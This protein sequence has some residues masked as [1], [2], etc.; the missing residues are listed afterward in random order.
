MI[1]QP[2]IDRDAITKRFSQMQNMQ[3]LL[4]LLNYIKP[5]LY[6]EKSIAFTERQLNYFSLS[7]HKKKQYRQFFIPKKN[8]TLRT[9]DAPVAT[10]KHIQACLNVALQLLHTP[11]YACNGFITGKSIVDNARL[12]VAKKFVYNLDLKDFFPSIDQKRVWACLLLPPFNLGNS[13]ERKQIANRI[14]ILCCAPLK[15]TASEQVQIKSVLPQGAPTSPFLTNVV[16]QKLDRRLQGVANRFQLSYSR[17]A[18]DITFSS[19]K[20]FFSEDSEVVAEI[21]RIIKDQNFAVNGEKVRLQSSD[22]RQEVTGLIVNE[23]VNV[24]K[25]YIRQLR[26]WIYL[27]ETYGHNKAYRFFL[28]DYIADRGNVKSNMP[29]M[30]CVL[31]G[32]LDYLKMVKGENDSVYKKLNHRYLTLT[33]PEEKDPVQ[34]INQIFQN[35]QSPDDVSQ[36]SDRMLVVKDI[37]VVLEKIMEE[38]LESAMNYYLN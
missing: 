11:H 21:V 15:K 3:E 29:S 18:D 34:K 28:K 24:P 4:D 14:A 8:G 37:T 6:G 1:K 10:L 20:N 2:R 19:N 26:Q 9:I 36:N 17:Y 5:T 22:F 38:G 23:K 27:W 25:K 32:K 16:S 33:Q 31:G 13:P 12:H 30:I 35:T 7:S